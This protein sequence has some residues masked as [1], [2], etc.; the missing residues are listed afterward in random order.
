MKTYRSTSNQWSIGIVLRRSTIYDTHRW[1]LWINH[2][3][4]AWSL[5][6]KMNPPVPCPAGVA[7]VHAPLTDERILHLWD[8]HV[9]YQTGNSLAL[10]DGD[11]IAFARAVL[12]ASG[13]DGGH[14]NTFCE[15]TPP[16]SLEKGEG[17][18]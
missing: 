5:S 2:G 8:T 4:G 15:Q 9:A 11:K 3:F 13:V 14:G 6:W 16:P 10:K 17:E 18:K 1:M 7:E 12:N